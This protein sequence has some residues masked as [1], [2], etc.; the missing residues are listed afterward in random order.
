MRTTLVALLAL[1]LARCGGDTGPTGW[2]PRDGTVS[3]VITA[4]EAFSPGVSPVA[5]ARLAH[6]VVGARVP[7]LARPKLAS[8]PRWRATPASQPAATANELIVTFRH[9]ALGAPRPGSAALATTAGARAWARAIRSHLATTVPAGAAVVGVSPTILA[10]KIRVADTAQREAISAALRQDPAIAAVTRNHLLWLDETARAFR[11]TAAAA[12]AA[13]RTIPNDP[14]YPFQAWHYALIDLPRAWSITKGSS[15]VLVAVVDDGIRFDHPGIAANLAPD[16]YDFVSSADSVPLCSGGMLSNA[17]DGDGPDPDPT[18]PA[19]YSLDSTR[20][21]F[22]PDSLGAH[23]LHVAGTIGA[24]GNDGIGVTGVNWSVRI[25][26]VRALGA[27]GFGTLYDVAQGILYAAGLPADDGAGGTVQATTG[28]RIINVSL[29]GYFNDP[30][31]HSAIVS[32][33]NTGALIVAAAGNDATSAPHYP[34]AY[35]EVLGVA[36]VGPDGAPTVYSN[37][38]PQVGIRAPGGNFGF[39]DATDG[40]YSTVWDFP[41]ASP[42]YDF[43]EGTSMATPHVAGVAALVLAQTPSLTA[44][45][46]RSRLTSYATGPQSPYGAGLVNAYNSLTQSFGP[47][48]QRLA[49]LYTATTGAIAQTV[50]A[51][52]GGAFT[53]SHVEDGT[54]FLYGGTIDGDQSLGAPG[55][56]WGPFGEL[57]IPTPLTVLGAG[58]YRVSFSIGVPMQVRPNHTIQTASGLALDGYVQAAI[59]DSRT[60]DVYRVQIAQP[61][62]YTFETSPWVGACGFALEDATQIGLFDAAG[63]FLTS[64][65]FLDP[66]RY[67]FCSRLTRTLSP[68]TYN[69]AVAGVF[70]GGVFGGRYRLQA[71]VGP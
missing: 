68:G 70:G 23:G 13:V 62:S 69:V 63:T 31:L 1:A 43:F 11:A 46:L 51:E 54:Y 28:A 61:G 42:D 16:G 56:L 9:T 25:R 45:E 4:S 22:A 65:G 12:A 30:T 37:F 7:A 21:C 26:P 48:T 38:G 50:L 8:R 60:L 44:A 14:A 66:R 24:V 36:A 53:F 18:I 39:G 6:A 15:A 33:A 5:A 55:S 34:S 58:P 29:G 19:S 3:G 64:A 71:R 17:A 27:A 20:T 32:A 10:A 40:V 67:N 41:R 2:I 47:P 35:P 49:R 57:A 52:A 59:V